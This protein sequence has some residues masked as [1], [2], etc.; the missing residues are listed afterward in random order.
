MMLR[1]LLACLTATWLAGCELLPESS[2]GIQAPTPPPASIGGCHAEVPDFAERDCLLH[3]WIAFGLAAQRGDRNWREAMLTR[4]EGSDP[5]RRLARAVALTWGRQRQW[6]QASELFK[7]DLHAAPIELQPML[8]YWLNEVER[9]R[10]LA[11][12]V[13]STQAER[14]ALAAENAALVEKLEALT[15]IE[16]NINLRQQTDGTGR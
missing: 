2:F 7:A 6:D 11:G 5:Q 14:D 4:L 9:R 3:D 16:Q 12:R 13:A 8:R 15:A 1:P 10:A